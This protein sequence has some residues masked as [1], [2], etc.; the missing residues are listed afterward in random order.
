MRRV[1]AA[2]VMLLC[3]GAQAQTP[4]LR[5]LRAIETLTRAQVGEGLPVEF[6][7][8][9]IYYDNN[10]GTD[11]FVQNGHQAIYVFARPGLGLAPG[12]RVRVRGRTH[13]D[14]RPDI[15][16]DEVT[17]IRH[18]APPPAI[19]ADFGRLIRGDLDCMR[20]AVQA[21]VRSADLV[22]A[23]NEPSV[24]LNLE[25]NGG[26]INAMVV[27]REEGVFRQLLDSTV[28]VTGVVAAKTDSKMQLTG[29]LIEVPA[30]SD[31]RVLKRARTNPESL[32]LTPMNEVLSGYRVEDHSLRV[33][34]R[35]S[36]TYYQPGAVA[37]LQNGRQSLWINT[38]QE[39]RLRI[40][41][42]VDAT[43]FP[44][45]RN[46]YLTL[47]NSEIRGTSAYAPAGAQMSDWGELA[48]GKR[49]FDLVSVAGRVLAEVRGAAQD[50]YIL[51]SGRG[52]LFSAIFRHPD[53][54][55]ASL[56][57]MKQPAI[58][59]EIRVTG[60]CTLQYGSDPLGAPVAFDI[61]LRSFDDITVV[62]KPSWLNIRNLMYLS[63]LLVLVVIAAG[64]RGWTLER[65]M[66]CQAA[67][68]AAHIEAEADMER[69][70]SRILEEINARSP[71]SQTLELI[72]T[73]VS[74]RLEG[75]RCWCETADGGRFGQYPSPA[76]KGSLVEHA[77][78]SHSGTQLGTLLATG[79]P[80]C[81]ATSNALAMGAWLATLAIETRGLYTDLLHRSEFDLLTDVYNRFAF[82]KLLQA[83][84][85]EAGRQARIFGLI[86][87][88]L[89]HFKEVNDEYGHLAGDLYLQQAAERMKTQL[90]PGDVLARLGGDEFAVLLPSVPGRG[91][92]W[93]IA[94]RLE[95]C[96]DQSFALDGDR[97]QGSISVGI[98][99]YPED[100]TTRDTLLSAADAA[101][102]VA[103]NT[104]K[105]AQVLLYPG[106]AG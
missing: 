17:L 41:E 66:R 78:Q 8:T 56:P 75:A 19:Q 103:K 93:E 102:Y 13:L 4:A 71:L 90:R 38:Q 52:H 72:A 84:I 46:G 87:L 91:E 83:L 95:H 9:V 50:E 106:Q 29:I 76:E 33:R 58:G 1:S 16:Q 43:G 36:V 74:S 18:G 85:E 54:I 57:P 62:A 79:A 49:A 80:D 99:M 97:I 22:L 28:E 69:R 14:F 68:L 94:H 7:A 81:A 98:A 24:Y 48:S 82:D 86:Y 55:A 6:E 31:V 63:A 26:A 61:L 77:I 35:G 51:E 67:A 92:V 44:E 12:D 100:G 89:D 3:L 10:G 45:A 21:Q 2:L 88:D 105:P 96:F 34:T 11:L 42:V 27:G 65:R 5:S 32:P 59:S 53:A 104:K 64:V 39:G 60:I 37:V 30:I 15:V 73:F 40:G 20:V 23:Q 101:M 25:M 47:N 70:R